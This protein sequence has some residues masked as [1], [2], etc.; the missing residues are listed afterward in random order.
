MSG[1]EY[2]HAYRVIE[3]MAYGLEFSGNP[4]R[5]AFA[6][7]LH[8]VAKAMHDIEWVDSGDYSKGDEV[9]AIKAALGEKWKELTIEEALSRIDSIKEDLIRMWG[10]E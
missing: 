10:E 6:E 2:D 7:L 8:R 4:L 5:M 9:A 3:M 1:G